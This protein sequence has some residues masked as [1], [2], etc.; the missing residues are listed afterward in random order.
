MTTGAFTSEK[1]LKKIFS[2]NYCMGF[3]SATFQNNV[4]LRYKTYMEGLINPK[5]QESLFELSELLITAPEYPITDI[6]NSKPVY[7]ETEQDNYRKEVVEK[8][9]IGVLKYLNDYLENPVYP[10]DI[11][12]ET[13]L[14][15]YNNY[16]NCL[17]PCD[18]S[19]LK[20]IYHSSDIINENFVSLYDA[21]QKRKKS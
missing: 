2:N 13:I 8:I 14:D 3:F 10:I 19:S 15:L 7:K 20:K 4:D 9:E 11:K 18:M 6:K 1:F 16:L 12:M 17:A 21:F 5:L